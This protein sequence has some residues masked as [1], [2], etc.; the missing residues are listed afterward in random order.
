[1]KIYEEVTLEIVLFKEE[2]VRTSNT[3]SKGDDVE[4]DIFD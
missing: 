4:E 3:Y 1:M 2:V